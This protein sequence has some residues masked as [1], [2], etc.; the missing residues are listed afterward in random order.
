MQLIAEKLG[1]TEEIGGLLNEIIEKRYDQL[2]SLLEQNLKNDEDS[3]IHEM[4]TPERQDFNKN[5]EIKRKEYTKQIQNNS[6]SIKN[7]IENILSKNLS[8]D[9]NYLLKP[10]THLSIISYEVGLIQSSFDKNVQNN[11]VYS[12]LPKDSIQ[13]STINQVFTDEDLQSSNFFVGEMQVSS[14]SENDKSELRILARSPEFRISK[15]ISPPF[16]PPQKELKKIEE[17]SLEISNSFIIQNDSM[18]QLIT[19]DNQESSQSPDFIPIRPPAPL[20]FFSNESFSV[21]QNSA[22]EN[23]SNVEDD[24]NSCESL[25]LEITP[26]LVV[27]L[28]E[29]VLEKIVAEARFNSLGNDNYIPLLNI[30]NIEPLIQGREHVACVKNDAFSIGAYVDEVFGQ[31]DLEELQLNL[32]SPLIR[33]P[34]EILSKVQ[35]IEV[36]SFI[37]TEFLSFPDIIHVNVYL[38]LEQQK[39]NSLKSTSSEN[40]QQLMIETEHI[41]KKMIFDAINQCLQDYRPYGTKGQPM[42]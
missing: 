22:I 7:Y 5:L 42:P 3:L 41:H 6:K 35:E 21:N 32:K 15:K 14:D 1:K 11:S 39:E 9:P 25:L 8:N 34:F 30:S 26:E 10:K 27:Q 31:C 19:F 20:H 36:A 40:I 33:S 23:L 24:K 17:G 16:T 29:W 28:A 13:E 18:F 38:N 37:E 4:T 2:L 12:P